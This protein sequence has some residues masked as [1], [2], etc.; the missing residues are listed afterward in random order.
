MFGTDN[1]FDPSDTSNLGQFL[2]PPYDD[3]SFTGDQVRGFGFIHDGSV[4]TVFR[5]H[6]AT[7]FAQT[8]RI[9]GGIPLIADPMDP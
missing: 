1:N 3:V 2:P 9:P 4:D 8:P 7:V 5:F 6:G